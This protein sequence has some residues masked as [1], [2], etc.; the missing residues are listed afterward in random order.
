[1][2]CKKCGWKLEMEFGAEINMH[3]PGYAGMDK[4]AVLIFPKLFVC[5][6]CGFAE[7]TVPE[8]ELPIL[9]TLSRSDP[10]V[11]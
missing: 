5:L 11:S 1:M 3:I 7:F 8:K 10:W 4:P 6:E 2:P 9:K